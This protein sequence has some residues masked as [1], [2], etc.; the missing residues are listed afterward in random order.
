MSW[1]GAEPCSQR[2]LQDPPQ[3][4]DQAAEGAERGC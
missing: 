2:A 3:L 1:W 4:Q